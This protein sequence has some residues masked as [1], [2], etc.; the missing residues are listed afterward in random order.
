MNGQGGQRHNVLRGSDLRYDLEITLEDAYDGKDVELRLDT[1]A[2]CEPCQGT[3]PSRAPRR[4]TAPLR[5]RGQ[6]RASQGFFV[7]ERTCP[8]A[9]ARAR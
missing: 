1:T 8:A 2:A 6:V 4:A 5:R 9:A 3:A 7:V